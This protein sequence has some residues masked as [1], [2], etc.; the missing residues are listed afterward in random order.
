MERQKGVRDR[1]EN[2]PRRVHPLADLCYHMVLHYHQPEREIDVE[3]ISPFN[4]SLFAP[5]NAPRLFHSL[6]FFFA[7]LV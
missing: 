5:V 7:F 6:L 4:T 1:H 3:N 2:E